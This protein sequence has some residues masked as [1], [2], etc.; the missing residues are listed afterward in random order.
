MA[1]AKIPEP[2]IMHSSLFV[3]TIALCALFAPSYGYLTSDVNITTLK[4]FPLVHN[5]IS[6]GNPAIM[7][8]GTDN[9]LYLALAGNIIDSSVPTP[10]GIFRTS[11][12]GLYELVVS[13]PELGGFIEKLL[14]GQD[15]YLYACLANYNPLISIPVSNGIVKIDTVAK[16]YTQFWNSTGT[17]IFPAGLAQDSADNFYVSDPVMGVVAKVTPSG[18][19]SI[20]SNDPLLSGHAYTGANGIAISD[21]DEFYVTNFDE[22]LFLSL[23]IQTGAATVLLNDTILQNMDQLN[24]SGNQKFIYSASFGYGTTVRLDLRNKSK[25]RI[26]VLT[27]YSDGLS[28]SV[29][30]LPG[31][32][33]FNGLFVSVLDPFVP[34]GGRIAQLIPVCES[35]GFCTL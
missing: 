26:G 17:L 1:S 30:A 11:L 29:Q 35:S 5:G 3:L 24:F 8:M 4:A 12:D 7:A 13:F 25:I 15:G 6:Y 32:D 28:T 22:H 33:L 2:I 18:I 16:T 21:E 31:G 10:K 20:F 14:F 27:T 34:Q 9:K 19:G 23:D